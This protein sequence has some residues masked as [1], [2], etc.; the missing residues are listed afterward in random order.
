MNSNHSILAAIIL[1][2]CGLSGCLRNSQQSDLTRAE[3][4]LKIGQAQAALET[5]DV[6]LAKDYHSKLALDLARFGAKTAFF[7]AKEYAI[8]LRY[9]RLILIKSND[10]QER[11]EAQKKIIQILYEK[12]KNYAES[13]NEISLILQTELTDS[14]KFKYRMM[15]AKSYFQLNKFYQAKV[16]VEVLV[17]EDLTPDQ[18]F[19]L[20]TFKGN[21]YMTD[22]QHEAAIEVYEQMLD[23]FNDR[24]IGEGVPLSLASVFEDI[25]KFSEA[26]EVLE[27]YKPVGPSAEFIEFKIKKLKER[28]KNQPGARGL[29]K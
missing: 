9:Y 24:A 21:L 16:E 15:L 18:Q 28:M 4:L 20:L 12:Q 7:E 5:I 6:A 23:A 11:G 25:E 26:I 13:I 19:Q 27:S 1:F 29:R 17:Q 2:F 14:E 10:P 3:K 8:A 22:K